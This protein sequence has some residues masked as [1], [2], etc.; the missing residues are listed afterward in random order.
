MNTLAHLI[1]AS[2]AR[3]PF[4]H[5][6]LVDL[7]EQAR[8]ANERIGVTGMLLHADGNFFQILEGDRAIIDALFAKIS[9]DPRHVNVVS[10]ICEPIRQRA[11]SDWSM[12]FASLTP[13]DVARLVGGN[14]FFSDASCFAQLD[15]G[16]ARK[17]LDAF[18]RGRWR[19]H[20]SADTGQV[21]VADRVPATLERPAAAAAIAHSFAYQPIV[22]T[23][24]QSLFSYE[25]LIRGP[26]GESAGSVL[27]RIA[28]ADMHQ[29]D[30]DCR[31]GALKLAARLGLQCN[32]NLN[33]LP[34]SLQ[35]CPDALAR[36]L[37]AADEFG[38]PLDHL[39]LEVTEGE[40]VQDLVAFAQTMNEL[41][42]SGVKLAI[43]DFGA[44]YAGLAM[45]ADFQPDLIKIDMNLVR[46]IDGRGPRQ[47]IVLA[48]LQVC[49]DLGIE[50]IAEGVETSGEKRWFEDAGVRLFQGYLFGRPAFESLPD[51]RFPSPRGSHADDR[52]SGI[53][54]TT[55]KFATSNGCAV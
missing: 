2:S 15:Q 42:R 16:R 12:G 7:L 45:L 3:E 44:G 1:Y 5:G 23:I 35:S 46:G 39:V 54:V 24:D 11:F 31:V 18:A 43:D 53:P 13:A 19:S 8:A 26:N 30:G 41:R 4:S 38:I 28:E 22:D 29:F 50:V 9:R 10:I 33:F 25:A 21:I 40:V 34:R 37:S 55:A 52:A 20:V 32:I 6:Q 27:S 51:I 17:L 36:L 48:I 49:S 14:D 47:A